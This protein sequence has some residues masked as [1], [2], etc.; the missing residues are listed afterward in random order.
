[1]RASISKTYTFSA[2]HYLTSVEDGH[3]CATMHGHNYDVVVEVEDD[4]GEDG[5]VVDYNELDDLVKP[6]VG[7]LDHTTLNVVFANPTAENLAV[8]LLGQLRCS[9]VTVRETPGTTA[10]ARASWAG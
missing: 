5:M 3:P 9:A 2:A 10:T 1:M 8:Y 7:K 6:V 4:I